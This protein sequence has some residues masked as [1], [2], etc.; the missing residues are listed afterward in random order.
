MQTARGGVPPE[1]IDA[2]IARYRLGEAGRARL[3]SALDAFG[4]SP[5]SARLANA[6][7]VESEEP[8]RVSV[9]DTALGGSIDVLAWTGDEALVLDYKTGRAPSGKTRSRMSGYALQA[10]C[11]ALAAFEAGARRVEAVFCFV[12]QGARGVDFDFTAEEDPAIRA[13]IARRIQA[14]AEQPATHLPE[15][16]PE[17]CAWCP[18]LGGVCPID[19]PGAGNRWLAS[20]EEARRLAAGLSALP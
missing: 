12:E 3:A 18:A 20:A 11:Y 9:G 1:S 2:A 10:R 16:D 19:P 15:Y 13:D 14:I 7:R 5:F 4:A 8:I 17:A 6:D